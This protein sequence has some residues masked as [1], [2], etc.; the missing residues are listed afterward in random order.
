[1]APDV[2]SPARAEPRPTQRTHPR[3]RLS[4]LIFALLRDHGGHVIANDDGR[5]HSRGRGL[6]IRDVAVPRRL[7]WPSSS[8]RP[9]ER[10][11]GRCS[12]GGR[13]TANRTR[14][15]LLAGS[16]SVETRPHAPVLAPRSHDTVTYMLDRRL[17]AA[18]RVDDN[19]AR[20]LNPDTSGIGRCSRFTRARHRCT[21]PW[22][23]RRH[24]RRWRVGHEGRR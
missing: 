2:L 18:R 5:S 8:G 15:V 20:R 9:V 16:R 13:G 23:D 11:S 1:M 21:P 3:Q 17:P 7:I 14:S 12:S 24:V 22:E 4:G 6:K 10:G 19:P